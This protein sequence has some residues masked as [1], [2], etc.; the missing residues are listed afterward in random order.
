MWR[1]VPGLLLALVV[2]ACGGSQADDAELLLASTTTTEDTSLLDALIP[3]F[4]E[5]SGYSV[6]LVSGGSGQAIENGRLGNV[7]VLLVHSPAAEK[8]MVADG[9]GIERALVMHNDFVLAGPDDDPAGVRGATDIHAALRAIV[10]A[11]ARFISRGDDSGTHVAELRLWEEAGVDPTAMSW[12]AESGQGQGATLLIASQ[13]RAYAITD[14]GTLLTRPDL[15]LAIIVEGDEGLLN[16]YHV[17][18]VNPAKH[19]HVNVDA[20]RAWAA[21]VTGERGQ[22]IIEEF[23]VEDYGEPI[24]YPDAGKPDPT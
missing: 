6:K 17:I 8:T 9:D 3:A 19:P 23:G 24:F 21:F 16:Y 22:R 18:V 13:Q 5:E 2:V 20:A 10:T 1:L 4:E 11:G 15:G 14:R 12:Y 7:D